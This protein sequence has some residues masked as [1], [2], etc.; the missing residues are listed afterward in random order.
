MARD[1]TVARR[2]E[3]YLA[4]LRWIE[5]HYEDDVDLDA[6]ARA[7]QVPRRTLQR[8]FAENGSGFREALAT[9][10]M[11]VAAAKLAGTSTAIQ[12]IAFE[13]GYSQPAQFAK[14]FRRTYNMTP[15]A[16]RASRQADQDRSAA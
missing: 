3:V 6:A 1:H 4:A 2:R 16:Y 15:T 8:A 7:L 10:R 13:V 11:E 14:A 5:D 9:K 12:A